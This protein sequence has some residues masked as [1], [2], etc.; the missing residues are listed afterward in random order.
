MGG[1][2]HSGGKWGVQRLGLEHAVV[3]PQHRIHRGQQGGDHARPSSPELSRQHADQDNRD[4]PEKARENAVLRRRVEAEHRERAQHGRVGRRVQRTVDQIAI[5]QELVGMDE[6]LAVGQQVGLHVIP[7]GEAAHS[8]TGTVAGQRRRAGGPRHQ[9]HPEA[10]DQ[11]EYSCTDQAEP[12]TAVDRHPS[13]A[14]GP[15]AAMSPR[16]SARR[17]ASSSANDLVRSS[18]RDSSHENCTMTRKRKANAA[19]KKVAGS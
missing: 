2:Q 7:T 5:G 12:I 3:D 15:S 16:T 1:Q 13:S 10:N 18:R 8:E 17:S 4:D 11:A 9:H 19:R 14:P 6:D